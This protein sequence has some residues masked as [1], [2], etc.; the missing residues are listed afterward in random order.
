M[1]KFSRNNL[2]DF[3]VDIPLG[4]LVCVT[5]VSGSGKTTLIRDGLLPALLNK[6]GYAATDDAL[7]AKL[8]GWR[9]LKSVMM[10][11]CGIL[12]EE[13]KGKGKRNKGKGASKTKLKP[14]L[15]MKLLGK[16]R[17]PGRALPLPKRPAAAEQK[18]IDVG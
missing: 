4:R 16:H 1:A 3:G 7:S 18:T 15:R 2:N 5:G 12:D 6:L 17:P 13:Q 14:T 10:R 8:T 11:T 9:A